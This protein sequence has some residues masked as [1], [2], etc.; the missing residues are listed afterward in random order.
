M[1]SSRCTKQSGGFTLVEMLVSLAILSILL[2]VL[3]QANSALSLAIKQTTSQ[4]REFQSARDAF[5]AM[6]RRI[7]QATLNSYDDTAA[8]T[9]LTVTGYARASELRF[10]SGPASLTAT[11]LNNI[12]GP[13]FASTNPYHPTHAIFFQAPLGNTGGAPADLMKA[14][15]TCGYYLEWNTDTT[16]GLGI[17]PSIIPTGNY[18]PRYRFRL[19]E[20]VEPSSALTIYKDT[21]GS[22][23][24]SP[25]ANGNPTY[26]SVSW[27]YNAK[28]W[29][30]TPFSNAATYAHVM[31][32]N[33]VLLCFLPMVSPELAQNPPGGAADGTS[34]DIAPNYIY[35]SAPPS[36]GA[37]PVSMNQLP[38]MVFVE[39]IAVDETSFSTYQ[40]RRQNSSASPSD[41]GIDSS[42]SGSI[43]TDATY[44]TR[45]SD[46][47]T[48]TNA[49]EAAHLKY[50][51]YSTIVPLTAH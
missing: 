11:A 29:F 9:P 34:L 1:S 43:L 23:A 25:A 37:P 50:R 40:A 33:V 47:A 39:M 2:L 44:T 41:L 17:V 32:E 24:G 20:M 21:S 19:M 51:I 36:S 42:G 38:P 31:A 4:E 46:I 26:F 14:L 3:A 18:T 6:T 7:S 8:Y 15:N 16:A 27:K 49:L 10:I 22:V 45:Q 5:E 13:L 30:Q 35:D 12:P 48:V 28:D